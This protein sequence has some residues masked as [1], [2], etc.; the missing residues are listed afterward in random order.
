[1]DPEIIDASEIKPGEWVAVCHPNALPML[2]GTP[3]RVVLD[4]SMSSTVIV[5]REGPQ[6]DEA[7]ERTGG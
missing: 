6:E 3:M 4:S 2:R 7:E 5:V 1:M